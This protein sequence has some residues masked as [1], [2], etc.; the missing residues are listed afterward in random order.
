MAPMSSA[1]CAA[2]SRVSRWVGITGLSL[3]VAEPK[4]ECSSTVGVIGRGPVEQVQRI[5]VPAQRLVRC[6]LSQGPVSGPLCV[7]HRLFGVQRSGGMGPVVGELT[8]TITGIVAVKL[9]QG[10]RHL[11]VG[12]DPP[13]GGQRVHRGC[14][15]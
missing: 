1:R 13:A 4:E 15:R 10:I 3:G 7:D 12:P 5:P 6:E 8:D 11:L 9:L 14:A 2:L